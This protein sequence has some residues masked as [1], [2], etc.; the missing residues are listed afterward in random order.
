MNKELFSR[1]LKETRRDA[2]YKSQES[3]AEA[4]NRRFR[5]DDISG[6][7]IWGTVKNYENPNKGGTQQ[8]DIVANMC[9]ILGCDIDYLAGRM[10]YKAQN[11]K[12]ICAETGLSAEAVEVLIAHKCSKA[13]T[14]E[15][16]ALM[17][18]PDFETILETLSTLRENTAEME[19]AKREG[20]PQDICKYIQTKID[21]N[22]IHVNHAIGNIIE[23]IK[24]A[25]SGAD[26]TRSGKR[27]RK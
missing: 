2:G 13:Y 3:F 17:L 7:G 25:A 24:K 23:S 26:N 10:D 22:E 4:Y 20:K 12:Y 6:S 5:A 1:R 8:L 19:K 21:L 9:D 27:G 11:Q 15:L 18:N 14:D 16:S